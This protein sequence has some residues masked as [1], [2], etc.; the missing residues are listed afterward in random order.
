M[1]LQRLGRHV[2]SGNIAP[3][4]AAVSEGPIANRSIPAVLQIG[5]GFAA[6]PAAAADASSKGKITQVSVEIVIPTWH[7]I[8]DILV[9]TKYPFRIILFIEF[10]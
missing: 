8:H 10:L 2:V 5:R 1:G 6:E 3:A 9:H 7:I 4:A